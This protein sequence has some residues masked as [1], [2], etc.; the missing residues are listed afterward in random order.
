MINPAF[1]AKLLDFDVSSYVLPSRLVSAV[2]SANSQTDE[3]VERRLQSVYGREIYAKLRRL[4]LSRRTFEG[5][6]VLEVCC[7]GGFLTY[8]LLKWARPRAFVLNDIS[9]SEI[10]STRSMLAQHFPEYK[11]IQ[12]LSGDINEI[13][14]NRKFDIIIGNSFLH[15]IYDVPRFLKLVKNLL[16][17]GGVFVSLHE[18]TPAALALEAGDLSTVVAFRKNIGAIAD[19]R[20]FAG[21]GLQ[22]GGGSDVWLFEVRKAQEL[23]SAAG[24]EKSL[25]QPWN[26]L[27]PLFIARRG[28]HL[29]ASKPKLD[30]I[31]VAGLNAAY[32]T[33]RV[34]SAFLPSNLFGSISILARA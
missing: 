19:A 20:R 17:P 32:R 21:P 6:Q 1:S 24:F 34:L 27:R 5:A 33:D 9:V 13:S 15:H 30:A 23:L 18:P 8:H 29:S 25:V 28:A 7:G 31:D 22:A 12:A 16:A 3:G 26:L 10:E 14:S 11:N 4:G 2:L